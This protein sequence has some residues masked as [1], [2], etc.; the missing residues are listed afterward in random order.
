M[1]VVVHF[2]LLP[3]VAR[4]QEVGLKVPSAGEILQLTVPC[5]GPLFGVGAVSVSVAV[6][7]VEVPEVS[8]VEMHPRVRV[9]ASLLA[10]VN[11]FWACDWLPVAVR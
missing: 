10:S 8:V 4:V 5:G 2:E 6:H 3:L 9:F 1:K 7:V 11:V